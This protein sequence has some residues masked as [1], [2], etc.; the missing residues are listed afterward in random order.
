MREAEPPLAERHVY[1]PERDAER[2]ER[3][4]FVP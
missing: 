2:G 1:L 3:A 4:Q